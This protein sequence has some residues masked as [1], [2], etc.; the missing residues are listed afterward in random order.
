[1][2]LNFV[3]VCS[4]IVFKIG[5]LPLLKAAQYE[6]YFSFNYQASFR[7][8]VHYSWNDHNPVVMKIFLKVERDWVVKIDIAQLKTS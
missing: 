2:F 4:S 8:K 6:W 1:M 3:L 7:P 5:V